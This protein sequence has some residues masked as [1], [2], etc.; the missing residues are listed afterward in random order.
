MVSTDDRDG[1]TLHTGQR[2]TSE[3]GGENPANS[4]GRLVEGGENCW[5]HVFCPQTTGC[6]K[7]GKKKTPIGSDGGM[8]FMK[9][10]VLH[11]KQEDSRFQQFFQNTHTHTHTHT[12]E[13][14]AAKLIHLNSTFR[15]VDLLLED[16]CSIRRV[17]DGANVQ[18]LDSSK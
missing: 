18:E 14:Q 1:C 11:L 12:P 15:L 6:K 16:I 13:K 10:E 8:S 7:L 3:Q 4:G 5:E 2:G 17:E 9:R